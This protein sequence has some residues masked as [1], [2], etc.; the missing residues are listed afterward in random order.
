MLSYFAATPNGPHRL[1]LLAISSLTL[2]AAVVT[3]AFIDRVSLYR[4]R[5]SFRS[6]R[7]SS[8]EQP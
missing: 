5:V 2:V 4:W 8:R 3:L 1:V 6:P 7:R